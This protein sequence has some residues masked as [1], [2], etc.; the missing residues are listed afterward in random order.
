MKSI[1]AFMRYDR[2]N[3]EKGR[4][5]LLPRKER[6]HLLFFFLF[7]GL[8]GVLCSALTGLIGKQKREKLR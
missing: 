1:I 7:E 2:R 3:R 5:L 4:T 8:Q 6:R